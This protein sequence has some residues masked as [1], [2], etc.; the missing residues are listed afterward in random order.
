MER[1]TERFDAHYA[2]MEWDVNRQRRTEE[3]Q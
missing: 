1:N 2:K 3:G